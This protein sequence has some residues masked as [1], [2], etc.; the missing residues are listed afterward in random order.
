MNRLE[1]ILV[2]DDEVTICRLVSTMLE[3]EG[4]CVLKAESSA[5]ALGQIENWG[6]SIDLLVTDVRMRGMDGLCLAREF[7]FRFPAARV[8]LMSGYLGPSRRIEGVFPETWE[9]L[10]KPFSLSEF[11]SRVERILH[12]VITPFPEKQ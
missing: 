4:Y 8:L 2:V 9:Y 12:G 7:E 3:R 10:A 11:V 1:T 5:D 6:K